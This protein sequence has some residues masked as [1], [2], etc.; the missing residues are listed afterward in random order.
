MLLRSFDF[1]AG[2]I[3]GK[4][5]IYFPYF[6]TALFVVLMPI[7]FTLTLNCPSNII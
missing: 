1:C 4:Y 5:P 6:H 2:F 7:R 3:I